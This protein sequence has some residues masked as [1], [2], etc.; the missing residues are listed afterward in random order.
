MPSVQSAPRATARPE[1]RLNPGQILLLAAAG[2]LIAGYLGIAALLALVTATAPGATLSTI[3][4][5]R[6][7]GPGWLAVYHVPI[8]IVGHELG[9][10]PLLPTAL[11]LALVGRSAGNAARRL[12]WDTPRSAARVIGA[13]GAAHAVF[14]TVITLL[15]AGGHVTASPVAAFFGA[16]LLAAAAATVGTARQ[17]RLLPAALARADDATETG[18]RAGGFA[19][20]GLAAVG[21]V[22]L[23]FGL[24]TSWST[25]AQL[26]PPGFGGGLGMF[27]LSIAYLPNVLI[28]ALSFAA[29]PGFAIGQVHLAQWSFH[30]GA[31]PAVPVLAALPVVQ[32]HWWPV[33]ML[34]PAGVGV[35]VGLSCRDSSARPR[36][37]AVAALVAAMSALVLAALAGGGMAGGPFDPVTVPSGAL[38]VAVFLLVGVPGVL[39]VLL[40]GR[41]AVP[42]PEYEPEPE[43]EEE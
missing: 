22:V 30:G 27:L 33:L 1:Q 23:A 38:A 12:E 29:G 16:G 18:L 35:L 28:G 7:A 10:L 11:A 15:C 5:L 37:V 17:C 39:T 24:L 14:G 34:L 6:T 19:V 42:E 2:P 40:K 36:S 20:L 8:D 25:A 9:V 13:I 32:A 3:G 41:G 43:P 21:A 31:V 4:V 26:F